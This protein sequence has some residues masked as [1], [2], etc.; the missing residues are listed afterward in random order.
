MATL[1]IGNVN[2]NNHHML[3]HIAGFAGYAGSVWLIDECTYKI[4]LLINNK[5][6][7]AE[8]ERMIGQYVLAGFAV[9]VKEAP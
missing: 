2:C 3:K 5:A 4:D 8:V 1:I 7:Q 6:E 9:S